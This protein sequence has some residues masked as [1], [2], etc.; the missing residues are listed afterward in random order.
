MLEMSTEKRLDRH[1]VLKRDEQS[2]MTFDGTCRKLM[3][4]KAVMSEQV[5]PAIMSV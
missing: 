4:I 2:P 1:Q 5:Y 3:L